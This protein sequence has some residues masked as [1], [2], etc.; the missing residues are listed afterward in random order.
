MNLS[1]SLHSH[2]RAIRVCPA[3]KTPLFRLSGHSSDPVAVCSHS[4]DLSF[5]KFLI[6]NQKYY[7]F[8]EYCCSQSPLSPEFQLFNS[9]IS[10]KLQ[11]CRP[12]FCQKPFFRPNKAPNNP[13]IS[14]LSAPEGL[15]HGR[16]TLCSDGFKLFTRL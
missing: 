13:P 1:K 7:K 9:K 10:L 8:F 11:V 3:V 12:Y 16:F 4:K 5:L 6:F 2:K 14:K 15:W